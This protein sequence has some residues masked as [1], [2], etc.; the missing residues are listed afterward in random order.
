MNVEFFSGGAMLVQS[1][2][3]FRLGTDSMVLADFAR[4]KKGARVCDLGTG[5]GAISLLLLARDK[6]LRVTGV[7]IQKHLADLAQSNA[8]MS[9]LSDCFTVLEGDLREIR[10]LLPMG[11]FDCVVSNPPY[12]PVNSPAAKEESAAIA[13]TELCCTV[14]D[15]CKAAA[16]L[17]PTGGK[18]YLVH[19]PERLSDV[20]CALRENGL[21]AKTLQFVRHSAQSKRSFL[22]LES[23]RGGKSGLSI[24]DDLILYHPDGT[25]T[26]DCRRIYHL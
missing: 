13:R 11:G 20:L 9:G 15:V 10:T 3:G 24:L 12:F 7:E 19:R 22:L 6:S 16:W 4:P 26:E 2:D 17:L 1:E 18:F 14:M 8:A 25:P 5:S 23:V 21:E